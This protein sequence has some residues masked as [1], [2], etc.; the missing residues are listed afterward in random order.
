VTAAARISADGSDATNRLVL[1]QGY[2]FTLLFDVVTIT[3]LPAF[4]TR[5]VWV[6]IKMP[7]PATRIPAM[8][9]TITTFRWVVRSALQIKWFMEDPFDALLLAK[10][11]QNAAP[12]E[13]IGQAALVYAPRL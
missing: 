11:V 1:T 6:R 8:R 3:G 12:A 4:I 7:K 10:N 5:T 13:Y 9:A 2:N